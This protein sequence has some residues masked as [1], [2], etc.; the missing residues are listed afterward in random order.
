MLSAALILNLHQSLYMFIIPESGLPGGPPSIRLVGGSSPNEGRVELLLQ[1]QWGTVC[2]DYWSTT[3]AQVI[4]RCFV[5]QDLG[6]KPS[7]T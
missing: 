7:G 4:N 3:D 6:K 2:D 1:G 5:Q